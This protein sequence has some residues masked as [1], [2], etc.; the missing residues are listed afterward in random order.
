MP[1]SG[2]SFPRSSSAVPIGDVLSELKSR[3]RRSRIL[4]ALRERWTEA[5]GEPWGRFSRPTG[6]R[7]GRLKVE[8][9]SGALLGELSGLRRGELLRRI[10]AVEPRVRDVA[11]SVGDGPWGAP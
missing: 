8:V 9:A 4:E 3:H 7:A 5:A 2:G 10:Q 11:F 1:K 6:L